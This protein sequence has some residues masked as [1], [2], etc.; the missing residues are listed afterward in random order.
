MSFLLKKGDSL[1]TSDDLSTKDINPINPERDIPKLD[2]F[3]DIESEDDEIG[4]QA[5]GGTYTQTTGNVRVSD[6][7]VKCLYF[8]PIDFYIFVNG[9]VVERGTLH[10]T[11]L[12]IF[13]LL[14]EIELL[15]ITKCV[16]G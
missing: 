7:K 8:P 15:S 3:K 10:C 12:L 1:P 5:A 11:M 14:N 2:V 4:D 6:S 9:S 16:N 13:F